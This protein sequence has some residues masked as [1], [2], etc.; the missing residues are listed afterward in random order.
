MADPH[1]GSCDSPL[2]GF[3]HRSWHSLP[4]H[5][6]RPQELTCEAF[7]AWVAG[8]ALT[9]RDLNY[10]HLAVT[11]KL[12]P[13]AVVESCRPISADV[14]GARSSFRHTIASLALYKREPCRSGTS[15][16]RISTDFLAPANTHEPC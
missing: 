10:Y 5:P 4:A 15:G 9:L 3:S 2:S 13:H 6:T 8:S 12:N 7:K 11:D 16:H 1:T 14:L